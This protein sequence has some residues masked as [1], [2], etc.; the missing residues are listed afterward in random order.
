VLGA[1]FNCGQNCCGVE[2]FYVYEAV[3]DKFVDEVVKVRQS[4]IHR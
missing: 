2:R 4:F 1:F 3:H